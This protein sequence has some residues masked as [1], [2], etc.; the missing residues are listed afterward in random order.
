MRP[1]WLERQSDVDS[2]DFI[3]GSMVGPSGPADGPGNLTHRTWSL[4]GT[5]AS[6]DRA[7]VDPRGL[8]T[9]GSAASSGGGWS[10]DWWIGADDRWHAPSREAAVRQRLV[11]EAPVVETSMRIP[12]GD[13]VQRVYAIHA[14]TD[15]PFGQAYVIVEVENASAV[16]FALT[17]AVCPY[18]PTGAAAVHTIT[19]EG[20]ARGASPTARVG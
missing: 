9:P 5:V 2:P 10:L 14:A 15:S 18:N 1:F 17:L 11:G 3:P 19:L 4:V 12:G 20:P 13:A 8:V 7:V 16:P 6:P